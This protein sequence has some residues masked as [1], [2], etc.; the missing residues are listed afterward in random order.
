MEPLPVHLI[1]SDSY[2]FE[3]EPEDIYSDCEFPHQHF[4]HQHY[5]EQQK[6]IR[7]PPLRPGYSNPAWTA[8]ERAPQETVV[9]SSTVTQPQVLTKIAGLVQQQK[10][11]LEAAGVALPTAQ[12]GGIATPGQPQAG[13]S[14]G[15]ETIQ[16]PTLSTRA[17][18]HGAVPF[19]K[20]PA[21]KKGMRSCPVCKKPFSQFSKLESHYSTSH[22]YKGKYTCEVCFK[23]FSSQIIL[24]RHKVIHTTFKCFLPGHPDTKHGCPPP[25]EYSTKTAFKAHLEQNVNYQAVDP[26]N[27]CQYCLMW[28]TGKTPRANLLRHQKHRCQF[29]PQVERE[30]AFCKFCGKR[31]SERRYCKLHEKKC[32]KGLQT[33]GRRSKPKRKKGLKSS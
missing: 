27:I 17:Q 11:T 7:Q 6:N 12:A 16:G 24:D 28:F 2:V 18:E 4:S 25:G 21:L 33:G 20:Y 9:V 19:K 5:P 10:S 23:P 32:V 8:T 15:G 13:T 1:Q 31:Y 3:E 14:T 26:E 30:Y 29:N 22:T